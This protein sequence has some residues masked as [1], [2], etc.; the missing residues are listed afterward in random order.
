[1]NELGRNV[2]TYVLAKGGL[3]RVFALW[4]GFLCCLTLGCGGSGVDLYDVSG[5][6]T[7]AGKPIPI[8]KI[9]FTPDASK[10]N[11]GPV[12]WAEIKNGAYNTALEGGQG[13]AGGPTIIRIEGLD[14]TPLDE[15]RPNGAPLFPP[16]ETTADLPKS[17][18]TQ[19]FE[20]PPEAAT[21]PQAPP[22]YTGP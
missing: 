8:G 9:Y 2:K 21:M 7:F 16:Y 18:A 6:V 19:N 5:N 1:M 3:I 20:V 15:E 13:I 14:G 22:V 4:L 17:N 12:G 10:G 11:E